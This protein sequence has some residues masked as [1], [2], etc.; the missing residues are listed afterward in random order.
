MNFLKLSMNLYIHNK[1]TQHTLIY[2]VNT[3]IILD[4][5]NR[6]T[7]LTMLKVFTMTFDQCIVFA[8]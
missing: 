4:S 5:I 2:Y 8:E 3:N 7:A 1:Y 6:L